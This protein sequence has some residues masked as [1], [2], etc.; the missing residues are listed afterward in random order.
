[1][2][3]SSHHREARY[4]QHA[5]W[6]VPFLLLWKSW[7]PGSS[8]VCQF[9]PRQKEVPTHSPHLRRNL[10]FTSLMA[11]C[12]DK[13]LE[14]PPHR[15]HFSPIYSLS[16]L[17]QCRLMD[18]FYFIVY[19]GLYSQSIFLFYC[20]NCPSFGHRE[21]FI[22]PLC[23]YSYHSGIF[24]TLK[25]QTFFLALQGAPGS[26]CTLS[27]LGLASGIPLKP[28]LPLIWIWY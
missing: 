26:P 24:W 15:L 25:K 3:S 13:I 6:L 28:L 11:E 1:M 16:H 19:G 12:F 10:C 7:P 20:S 4:H 14:V 21:S 22:W 18:L 17:H 5:V 8:S 27:V 2:L 23:P 9:L